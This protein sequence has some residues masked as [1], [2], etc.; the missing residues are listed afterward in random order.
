MSYHSNDFS[1][2]WGQM[3]TTKKLSNAS[4]ITK[5]EPAKTKMITIHM[6]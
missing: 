5:G 3:I 1:Q 2:S 6:F 4:K